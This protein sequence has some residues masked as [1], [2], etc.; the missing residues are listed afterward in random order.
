MFSTAV[1]YDPLD[2]TGNITIKWDVISWTADGYV[3][4]VVPSTIFLTPDKRRKTQALM[5]WNVTCT[6]SQFLASKHPTCCVSFSSFYNDTIIPCRSCACGCENKNCIRS[7]S[8]LL[9]TPGINTP[10]KDNAPLL[11][12]TQHMC[13][14]RVH[15]HVKLNYKDYW[16]AKIAITNFNYRMN[17][18]LWTLVIQHPNLDN[19]TEVFSFDYKP[20]VPYGFIN[21]TGM[22][23]GMKKRSVSFG[24]C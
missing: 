21:D 5:T 19:V 23:Y 6:Y 4:V 7:D 12:C 1:A 18:T 13:P 3:A 10:K 2:P 8:N 22:F 17:Y 16:R 24:I 9:T 14:V 11:Q 20:L 15:W